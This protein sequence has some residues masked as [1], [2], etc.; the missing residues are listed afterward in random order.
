MSKEKKEEKCPVDFK[1][2]TPKI[3]IGE[4]VENPLYIKAFL[5]NR[6][7]CMSEYAQNTSTWD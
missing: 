3:L 7:E 5:E 4:K 1:D 6:E 2:V